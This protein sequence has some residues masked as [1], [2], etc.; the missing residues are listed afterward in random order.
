MPSDTNK[1]DT[2][3]RV[4]GNSCTSGVRVILREKEVENIE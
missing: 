2:I 1:Y 4:V 3:Y